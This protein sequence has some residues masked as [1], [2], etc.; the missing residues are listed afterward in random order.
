[1]VLTSTRELD[2]SALRHTHSALAE[3]TAHEQER[4][5]Q[6]VLQAAAA[7]VS[8]SVR[9]E[10]GRLTISARLIT[11]DAREFAALS[12]LLRA[13]GKGYGAVTLTPLLEDLAQAFRG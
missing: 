13:Y 10:E 8:L 7:D 9:E 5:V 12:A 2:L 11:L 3:R 6:A 4:A 1:M